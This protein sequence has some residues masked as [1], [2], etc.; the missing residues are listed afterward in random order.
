MNNLVLS[1]QNRF[2][3]LG[4]IPLGRDIPQSTALEQFFAALYR[5]R[6][7]I[8]A[9]VSLCMLIGALISIATPRQFTASAS[10]QLDQQTPQIF[11]DND[12]DPTPSVQDSDR[13]LQTQLDRLRSR[14]IAKRVYDELAIGKS[15]AALKAIGVEPGDDSTNESMA[16]WA[17]QDH[18][19]ARLGLNTR[20][21]KLSFT[22]SDPDVSARVANGFADALAGSNTDAKQE[23]S[24][25]AKQYLLEQLAP[26][27]DRLET[28]EREMLAYARRADLTTTV[29]PTDGNNARGGS[30]RSQQ[31]G[32]MT[33]SLSQATARRIDAQQRWAQ[34]QGTSALS[35]PEVQGNNA[36][37]NLVAQ[38]AQL[39]AS[40]EENRQRY[41]EE[42]PAVREAAAKI[43]EL[44]GQI[45][46]FASSIRS[47]FYG[48]Y[49]AASQQERQMQQA[50]ASLRGAAMSERERSV[51][52][53]SLSREVETNKAFY[54]GLLQR[55]KE[56]AAAAGATAANV[57]VLDRAWPPFESD[58]RNFG[59]N[60][61]LGG[62]AGLML[63]FMFGALRERIHFVVRT[64]DDLERRMNIPALGVVPKIAA[65]DDRP[66]TV[67][68]KLLAQSEAYHS[69]AVALE[70][71]ASGTLPKTLLITSS[72]ASEG[73]STS[74]IGIA[75][76]LSAMGKKVLLVDGDLRRPSAGKV[77]ED[78]D[79]TIEQPDE[80]TNKVVAFVLSSLAKLTASVR[81]AY[82]DLEQ[83][84][85][86]QNSVGRGGRS[87]S[88][89][90]GFADALKGSATIEKTVQK[91]RGNEFSVVRAGVRNA[92][93]ISLLAT[94]KIR[95]MFQKLAAEH[96]IVIV[97]G[98]PVMGLA[99][100]VLLARSV[101][102][103]L[104]VTEA[105]RTL[106]TQLNVALS[107]LPGSNII[108]GI[109]T[110]FDAKAAGV[111]YGDYDY[112]SYDPSGPATD[113]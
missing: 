81:R 80:P 95:T 56:V 43:K 72:G 23:T 30:L 79:P 88:V 73:K 62:M 75:R 24:N 40:L 10:I 82:G 67:A 9:C 109:I 78:L 50:V 93:P 86:G 48:Q 15:P 25:K 102:A 111:H 8:I 46:G 64:T 71:A 32:L 83:A 108:G 97:D 51:G 1:E 33:D 113:A 66:E 61:A 18:M 47:S 87:K 77:A 5:Q 4:L 35:L 105:N 63:A 85:V 84:P 58:S 29:V 19:D 65:A 36:I 31:L 74:A 100:A 89:K 39:Q 54:D 104:V 90:P 49:L 53:N 6:Y 110:K 92:N 68:T 41:T 14:S 7:L 3:E 27:K 44:D 38:K 13:F 42:Y 112:Y 70:D 17:L 16:V 57:T 28:S 2:S 45:S 34:V 96:D 107:R 37:Q 20:L 99:D 60:L 55:Y 106:L 98:P 22:S 11:G 94:D 21:A 91:S 103:V 76:S 59:R 101:D 26:A 12:L 69:I 52:F